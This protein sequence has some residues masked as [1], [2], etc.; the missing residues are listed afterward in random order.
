MIHFEPLP[1]S[2]LERLFPGDSQMA[3][4]MRAFDWSASDFGPPENW[5]ENLRVAVSICL[6]CQFPIVIWWGPKFCLLFNDAY[7]PWLSEAKHPRVLGR[8]RSQRGG[9]EW[10]DRHHHA[11]A[12]HHQRRICRKRRGD[13]RDAGEP[14]WHAAARDVHRA[15]CTAQQRQ[16]TPLIGLSSPVVI[17]SAGDY[18]RP[19][20]TAGK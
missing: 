17:D 18:H 13:H 10:R 14:P 16:L 7:L 4:R 6:P 8:C 19:V 5:P 12:G 11:E 3:V 9:R 1:N 2:Q 20:M 15:G